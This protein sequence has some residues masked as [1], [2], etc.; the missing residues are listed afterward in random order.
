MQVTGE[1]S[2]EVRGGMEADAGT[3]S[4]LSTIT[5]RPHDSQLVSSGTMG[6]TI[7]VGWAAVNSGPAWRPPFASGRCYGLKH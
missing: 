7:Q 3:D 4:Q 6:P 1:F 5:S 2:G